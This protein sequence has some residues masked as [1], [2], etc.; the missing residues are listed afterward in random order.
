MRLARRGALHR[1]DSALHLV[2]GEVANP[3]PGDLD[4]L[5]LLDLDCR[6]AVVDA[7]VAQFR[8]IFRPEVVMKELVQVEEAT[9]E[10][11]AAEIPPAGEAE[12]A[13][14]DQRGGAEPRASALEGRALAQYHPA[15][16]VAASA[17]NAFSPPT[18]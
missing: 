14:G 17:S 8:Q 11:N 5:S 1:L 7:G 6:G 13:D 16:M 18:C 9:A 12:H 4:G 3:V 15:T 10:V 2:G